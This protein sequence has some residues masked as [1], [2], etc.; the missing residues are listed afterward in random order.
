[1]GKDA[2]GRAEPVKIKL[3]PKG[4]GIGFSDEEA[5]A[6]PE[7]LAKVEIKRE[8][9]SA[10][11]YSPPVTV[12]KRHP[13]EYKEYDNFEVE[14]HQHVISDISDFKIIDMQKPTEN[15]SNCLP[16][17]SI[18]KEISV[19]KR[20]EKAELTREQ[21]ELESSLRQLKRNI[22]EVERER[23]KLEEIQRENELKRSFK[24]FVDKSEEFKQD[25]D[26]FCEELKRFKGEKDEKLL[27]SVIIPIIKDEILN[28]DHMT[29]LKTVLNP[30]IYLQVIYYLWWVR[31]KQMFDLSD[32][33][34]LIVFLE[35]LESWLNLLPNEFLNLF[36]G[37]QILIPKIHK[38]LNESNSDVVVALKF[39][40][41]KLEI[42]FDI[43]NFEIFSWLS[44]RISR[45]KVKEFENLLKEFIEEWKNLILFEDFKKLKEIFW[46]QRIQ[47][48]LQRDLIIDPS[49]QD[50]LPLKCTFLAY[51]TGIIA[52]TQTIQLLTSHLIPKLKRC[53]QIWLKSSEVDFEEVAEWYVAWKDLIPTE[54]IDDHDDENG[55]LMDGFAEILT[56]INEHL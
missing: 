30:E 42:P 4:V 46:F 36:I 19:N 13:P 23:K 53:L 56:V 6:E 33:S 8:V 32:L 55:I 54:L 21:N 11:D 40:K 34:D 22:E 41:F 5:E 20:R 27:V 25:F 24:E 7:E 52:K 51:N 31:V 39:L 29:Q 47:K 9:K 49:D 48:L 12:K 50:L 38:L 45:V 18:L 35:F 14:E 3:R 10:V 15:Y 43:L 37:N 16:L 1:M 26:L 44:D 2:E 17:S 28:F